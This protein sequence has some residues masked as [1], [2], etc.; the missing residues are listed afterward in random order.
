[1]SSMFGR[2]K[3]WLHNTV[4]DG[5]QRLAEGHRFEAVARNDEICWVYGSRV[6]ER[7]PEGLIYLV[8]KTKGQSIKSC[9]SLLQLRER[10]VHLLRNLHICAKKRK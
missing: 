9:L 3:Y 8:R 1:M 7:V 6:E 2:R 5:S 10:V 4:G